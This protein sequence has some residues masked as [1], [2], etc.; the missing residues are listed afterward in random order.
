MLVPPEM[1]QQKQPI[2]SSFKL[3]FILGLL[4][5]IIDLVLK[6]SVDLVVYNP[7]SAFGTP[8]S[9]HLLQI[10]HVSVLTAGFR[11]ISLGGKIGQSYLINL[12]IASALVASL[13]NL[14]DRMLV[15]AVRDYLL[16]GPIWFNIADAVIS[17]AIMFTITRY[18]Y[19]EVHSFRNRKR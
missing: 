2:D 13:S 3:G 16:L 12:L 9:N 4:I 5:L 19:D 6:S 10:V 7:G 11:H 14:A 15:G 1:S 18:L 8:V 17:F